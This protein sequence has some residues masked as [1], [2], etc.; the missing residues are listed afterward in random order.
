MIQER[1]IDPVCGMPVI[2]GQA[3]SADHAGTIYWFCSELC[4]REFQL[5][6]TRFL[7]AETPTHR[8][9]LSR[10]VAYFSM[11]VALDP[12]LP[13]YAGGL[14][15]LA[16]DTL[17][18]FADLEVPVGAVSLLHEQGYFHQTLDRDGNQGES[19]VAWR[20]EELRP[21]WLHGYLAPTIL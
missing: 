11:E 7:D 6:P 12:R 21:N 1:S 2:P 18:S 3:R 5:A 17:R 15:V 16:G 10:R 4:R 19:P 9:A 14:D 20:P 8:D 13:T